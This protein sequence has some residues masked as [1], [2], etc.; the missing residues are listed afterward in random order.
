M[1]VLLIYMAFIIG[2]LQAIPH[3]KD[4]HIVQKGVS[5]IVIVLQALS[6]HFRIQTLMIIRISLTVLRICNQY[7]SFHRRCDAVF[8]S[9]TLNKTAEIFNNFL[10]FSHRPFQIGDITI[11]VHEFT[12]KVGDFQLICVYD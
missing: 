1:Q 10:L 11:E 7:Y 2:V 9:D 4:L 6:T 5:T 12:G 3:Q 8:E